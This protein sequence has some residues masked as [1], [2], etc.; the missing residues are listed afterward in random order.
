MY[1]AKIYVT[2]KPSIL[3]PQGEVIKSALTRLDYTGISQVSQGKYFEVKLDARD[4][5]AAT[6]EVKSF[7]DS[8]LINQNTETYR[9]DL[10]IVN[11]DEATL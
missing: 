2:Y 10:S 3:D 1:L 4:V 6:A 5:E 9:F 11:E 7:T 8:L